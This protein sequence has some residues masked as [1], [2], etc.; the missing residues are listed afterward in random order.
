MKIKQYF[1]KILNYFNIEEGF[2]KVMSIYPPNQDERERRIQSK[3]Q[4]FKKYSSSSKGIE[5]ALASDWEK[6]G[7]DLQHAIEKAEKEINRN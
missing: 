7:Q 2:G 5:N 6:V 1:K 4:K 3:L